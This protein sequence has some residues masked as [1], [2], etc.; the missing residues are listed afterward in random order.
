MTLMQCSV[1]RTFFSQIAGKAV[2]T[3]IP[4]ADMD[5]L[6][7]NGYISV[8]HGEQYDQALAEI[9][10][11]AKVN[12]ELAREEAEERGARSLLE[13][14][15][16]KTHS[17]FFHFRSEENQ[18]FELERE[19]IH[20]NIVSKEAADVVEKE[21]KIRE[22]LQ[23]KSVIDRMVPY[24]GRYVSLTGLGVI[25]LNDLNVR[26]YRVAE[27]E[28]S[29]FIQERIATFSELRTIAHK[30]GYYGICP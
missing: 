13:E 30:G 20:R 28:F 4:E 9:S 16:R 3:Q 5:F 12:E 14:D 15:E 17:I 19:A 11:L 23:K 7:T 26:N 29:D 1:V 10:N 25:T 24:D 21:S 2:S 22:L 6:T 18:K 8:I 27:T